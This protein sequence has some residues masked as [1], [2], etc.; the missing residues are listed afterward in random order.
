MWIHSET[1]TWHDK[2]MQSHICSLSFHS[3]FSSK[4]PQSWQKVAKK[5]HSFY[6]TVLL[7][8]HFMNLNS[9]NIVKKIPPQHSQRPYSLYKFSS[10]HVSG[11]R[12]KK[13]LHCTISRRRRTAFLKHLE[14]KCLYIPVYLCSEIY[15]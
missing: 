12:Q 14:S 4:K 6:N 10:K 11:W 2:N 7:K 8:I 9:L 3:R 5:D 13:H 15:V 1:R